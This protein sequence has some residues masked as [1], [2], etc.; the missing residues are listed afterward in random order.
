MMSS[1]PFSELLKWTLPDYIKK[2]ET[3]YGVSYILINV[4]VLQHYYGDI[5]YRQED[6]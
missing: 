5:K 4:Q 1:V 3:A 6:Y 2:K